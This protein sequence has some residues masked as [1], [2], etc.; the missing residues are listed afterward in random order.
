MAECDAEQK[1]DCLQAALSLYSLENSV[2]KIVGFGV[3]S[4]VFG[5]SAQALNKSAIKPRGG[6]AGG[7]PSGRYTSYTRRYFPNAGKAIGRIGIGAVARAAGIL[8]AGVGAWHEHY[9]AMK[10]YL[11]CLR[12]NDSD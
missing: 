3:G 9:K 2:N 12:E 5:G 8:G 10:E 11:K 1:R 4:A 7:G 6:V